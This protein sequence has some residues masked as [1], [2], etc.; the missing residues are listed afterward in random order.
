MLTLLSCASPR[1][2]ISASTQLLH[3]S[4]T[5]TSNLLLHSFPALINLTVFKLLKTLFVTVYLAHILSCG[6]RGDGL[7]SILSSYY[8]LN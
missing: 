7:L 6:E 2:L 1:L 5:F 4:H 3:A 8:H